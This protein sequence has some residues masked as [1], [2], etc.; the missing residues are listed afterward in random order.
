[1]TFVAD[2][3]IQTHHVVHKDQW[4]LHIR[5]V[6]KSDAGA[7]ECQISTKDRKL[8]KIFYLEVVGRSII[9]QDIALAFVLKY[10]YIRFIPE[11][12]QMY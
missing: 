9:T 7:Y 2:S 12:N 10:V 11:F 4:N 5:N 6:G 3:R 1:M 8:R